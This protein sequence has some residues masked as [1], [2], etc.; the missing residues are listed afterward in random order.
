MMLLYNLKIVVNYSISVLSVIGQIQPLTFCMLDDSSLS[1]LLFEKCFNEL[2]LPHKCIQIKGDHSQTIES[3][4]NVANFGGA[5]L[6]P[7]LHEDLKMLGPHTLKSKS[8]GIVDTIAVRHGKLVG[9]NCLA[10]GIRSSLLRYNSASA[11]LN[12]PALVV[13]SSY[14]DAASLIDVLMSLQCQKIYILGF[15]TPNTLP[16]LTT[17]VM[18][19]FQ[20]SAFDEGNAS[21]TVVFSALPADKADLLPPLINMVGQMTKSTKRPRVFLDLV[22][23]SNRGSP[24]EIARAAGWRTIAAADVTASTTVERLR[25][26][27]DQAVPYGFLKMVQK[28]G[29]Y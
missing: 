27:A 17:L 12:K 7:S 28:R 29:L 11:Y 22:N 3:M 8:M 5:L 24:A 15:K 18:E 9:Y 2:G 10:S 1:A 6:L 26:L 14:R 20:T 21:L 4:I 19:Q 23:G 13:A 16:P 25:I